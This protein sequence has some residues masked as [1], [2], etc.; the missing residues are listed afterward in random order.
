MGGSGLQTVMTSGRKREFCGLSA[1]RGLFSGIS[2]VE[3]TG[4]GGGGGQQL[5][6]VHRN[7]LARNNNETVPK[8]RDWRAFSEEKDALHTPSGI[9]H[10]RQL[11]KQLDPSNKLVEASAHICARSNCWAKT[12]ANYISFPLFV[13]LC[14]EHRAFPENLECVGS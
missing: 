10:K 2:C 7:L 11:E 14:F 6:P 3:P 4:L 8:C 9:Y 13:G 5:W 1:R 12:R